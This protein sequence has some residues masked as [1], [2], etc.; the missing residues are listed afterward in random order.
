[1]RIKTIIFLCLTLTQS[2]LIFAQ[3]TIPEDD[4]DGMRFYFDGREYKSLQEYK[5][6]QMRELLMESMPKAKEDNKGRSSEETLPSDEKSGLDNVKLEE[7]KRMLAEILEEKKADKEKQAIP[8]S[9]MGSDLYWDEKNDH[10]ELD[11]SS[12]KIID[13]KPGEGYQ[14]PNLLELL[15]QEY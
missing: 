9:G 15:N 6:E 14:D 11:T 1:M 5:K 2:P 3:G 4:K 12:W 13:L 7:I 10:I 8:D